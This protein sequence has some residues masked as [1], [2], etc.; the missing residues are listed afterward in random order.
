[1][2]NT[3]QKTF[4]GNFLFTTNNA[5]RGEKYSRRDDIESAM[6]LL[7]YLLNDCK[8]PWSDFMTKFPDQDLKFYFKE[9]LK[10]IY[11]EKIY[12]MAPKRLHRC[13]RTVMNTGFAEEPHYREILESLSSCFEYY[14]RK[15]N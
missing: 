9:R 5:L 14:W 13:L 15:A 10:P 3:I 12:C 7:I 6:L 4:S 2:K 1:M 8:L 11:T